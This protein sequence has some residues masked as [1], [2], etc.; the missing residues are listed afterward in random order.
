MDRHK[1]IPCPTIG[2]KRVYQDFFGRV[3]SFGGP[4]DTP[5]P[6]K[7]Q[8]LTCTG[9]SGYSNMRFTYIHVH[10]SQ[11]GHRNED[12]RNQA[13]YLSFFVVISILPCIEAKGQVP[14]KSQTTQ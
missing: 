9:W 7:L 8:E 2:H 13:V 4:R 11:A 6:L 14:H 10:M 5:T 12:L 1:Y 3:C